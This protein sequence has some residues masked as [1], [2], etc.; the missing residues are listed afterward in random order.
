MFPDDL[1][2]FGS[3]SLGQHLM[4]RR[5]NLVQRVIGPV[6]CISSFAPSSGPGTLDVAYEA[7]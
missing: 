2:F 3:P 1:I 6:H 4:A 5:L 7:C